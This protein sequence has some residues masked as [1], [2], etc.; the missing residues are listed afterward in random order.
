VAAGTVP[1]VELRNGIRK[2]RPRPP[3][4]GAGS[5]TPDTVQRRALQQLRVRRASSSS[6]SRSCAGHGRRRECAAE[7]RAEQQHAAAEQ[8]GHAWPGHCLKAVGPYALK[9]NAAFEP[10]LNEL[11]GLPGAPVR[12]SQAAT[13]YEQ[14]SANAVDVGCVAPSSAPVGDR[15]ETNAAALD[16]EFRDT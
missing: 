15:V 9:L 16:I 8:F 3:G 5:A 4:Y 6:G 11:A 7:D 2:S 13:R 10:V 14:G 12:I 1:S